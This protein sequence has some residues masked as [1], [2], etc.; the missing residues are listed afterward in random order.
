LAPVEASVETRMATGVGQDVPHMR[1]VV[2]YCMLPPVEA[3]ASPAAKHWPYL[4]DR[5]VEVGAERRRSS[6]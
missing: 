2:V 5:G 6:G 3:Q 1:A 4:E